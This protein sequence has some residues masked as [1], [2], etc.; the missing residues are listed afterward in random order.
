ML[1]DGFYSNSEDH[2][3]DYDEGPDDWIVTFADVSMLLLVFFCAAVF[4]VFPGYSAF[5][6]FFYLVARGFGR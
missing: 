4:H 2:E 5:H 3:D 1:D 6:R